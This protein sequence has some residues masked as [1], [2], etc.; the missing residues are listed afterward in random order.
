VG[1]ATDKSVHFRV[2]EGNFVLSKMTE[3]LQGILHHDTHT[4]ATDDFCLSDGK[5]Q[6]LV[7]HLLVYAGAS[8]EVDVRQKTDQ[9]FRRR[10]AAQR[11]PTFLL[12]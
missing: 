6:G 9:S 8:R 10:L 2:I 4:L 11:I 5:A 12:S 3:A 1:V 7:L